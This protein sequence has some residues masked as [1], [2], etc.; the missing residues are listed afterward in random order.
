MKKQPTNWKIR[1]KRGNK[2]YHVKFETKKEKNRKNK[3]HGEN[4]SEQPPE[5]ISATVG[6]KALAVI[7]ASLSQPADNK[8]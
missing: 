5:L 2:V 8:F 7:S 1:K 3:V 6:L 4:Y